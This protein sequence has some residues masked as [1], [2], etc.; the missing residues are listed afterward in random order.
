MKNNYFNKNVKIK[1]ILIFLLLIIYLIFIFKKSSNSYKGKVCICTIAK[2]E[3]KY[4]R[5]W[6]EHYKNYGVDKIY[7]YDNNDINGENFES[8][9][10]D[11]I[12]EGF[13][14]IFNWRGKIK[15]HYKFMNDCYNRNNFERDNTK[16]PKI[17]LSQMLHRKIKYLRSINK[18]KENDFFYFS[19][20]ITAMEMTKCPFT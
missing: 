16:R 7:L 10:D 19:L 15:I 13:V 2:E 5:E 9:I 8:V 1:Y 3:N 11:Y 6:T 4:I 14:E 20:I 18:L 17:N 12:K